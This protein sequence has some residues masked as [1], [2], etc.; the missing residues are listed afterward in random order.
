MKGLVPFSLLNMWRLQ[1]CLQSQWNRILPLS[2]EVCLQQ[3]LSTCLT[4]T[5][6]RHRGESP[7]NIP[8]P[9]GLDHGRVKLGLGR[10]HRQSADLRPMENFSGIGTHKHAG[11][12]RGVPFCSSLS[13]NSEQQ[14]ST[15]RQYD[16]GGVHQS[17]GGN[18]SISLCRLA[19]D[20]FH[21]LAA[22]PL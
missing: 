6:T 11:V 22:I 10:S 15:V 20:L 12:T 2:K 8:H 19:L 14:G 5:E 21:W 7:S 18:K 17:S 9:G 3:S 13:I 1:F 16:G 4:W